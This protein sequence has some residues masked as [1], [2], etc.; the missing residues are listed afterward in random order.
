MRILL[1]S[2][3]HGWPVWLRSSCAFSSLRPATCCEPH[4]TLGVWFPFGLHVGVL[5]DHDSPS[6]LKDKANR[7]SEIAERRLDGL[8]GSLPASMRSRQ[9][10]SKRSQGVRNPGC[11]L[12]G[13]SPG[14]KGEQE[15]GPEVR[16]IAMSPQGIPQ[17]PPKARRNPKVALSGFLPEERQLRLA[18]NLGIWPTT[19]HQASEFSPK[20]GRKPRISLEI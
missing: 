15:R 6:L 8:D 4:A 7:N 3:L 13:R 12:L 5:C 16:R 20:F 14:P 18:E 9:R 10:E 2:C 11:G 1:H 17:G 19:W